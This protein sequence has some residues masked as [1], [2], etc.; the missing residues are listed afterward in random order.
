[1]AITEHM[2]TG[3]LDLMQE[4]CS[5]WSHSGH[6]SRCLWAKLYLD[7]FILPCV[8]YICLYFLECLEKSPCYRKKGMFPSLAT[9]CVISIKWINRPFPQCGRRASGDP[10]LIK[11]AVECYLQSS[12]IT[13]IR[14]QLSWFLKTNCWELR[15]IIASSLLTVLNSQLMYILHSTF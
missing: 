5:D 7:P 11:T 3:F 9:L 12:C 6:R 14:R 10:L 15:Q 1:M 2:P 8:R 4:N 13:E